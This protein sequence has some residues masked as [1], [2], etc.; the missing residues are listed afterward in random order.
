MW[1]LTPFP[2]RP[3]RVIKYIARP[4]S[5]VL[6]ARLSSVACFEVVLETVA[7]HRRLDPALG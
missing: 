6:T 5:P 3:G 7:K 1:A 2:R 4:G